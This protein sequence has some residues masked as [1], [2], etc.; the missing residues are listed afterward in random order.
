MKTKSMILIRKRKTHNQIFYNFFKV[1]DY[2]S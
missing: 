2:E 1:Y